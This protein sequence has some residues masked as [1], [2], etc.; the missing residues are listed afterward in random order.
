M[1]ILITGAAGWTAQSIIQALHA[2]GHTLRGFDLP[3]ANVADS[4][5]NLL[6]D[7]QTGTMQA[8]ADVLASVTDVDAIVHAAV[9]I[10]S[11]DYDTPEMP[12]A[13]NVRGTAHVFEAARAQKTPPRII[14]LNS[15]TVHLDHTAPI[16]ALDDF[17]LSTE[18]DFL[19]DLTKVL[20]EDIA[21]RYC[22]TFSMPAITLRLG[23]IVDGRTH[24]DPKGRPLSDVT[25]NRGGWVCRYDVA[26]AVTQAL[27]Y[28]TSGYDAFHVI[29]SYQAR[30][31]F[32]IE[33][34]ER[35]LGH[36]CKVGFSDYTTP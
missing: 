11:H 35:L 20:Q 24:R 15:A 17:S 22:E 7:Y 30:A 4:V 16:R 31:T 2:D 26:D 19:Y 34:T 32:D 13:T 33:R 1:H 5:A 27:T 36:T 25:Y 23:H 3:S 28:S 29:G 18:G 9:A 21:R 14:L 6:T 8:Y 12:F 10:G